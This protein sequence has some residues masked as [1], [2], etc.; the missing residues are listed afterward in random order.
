MT[1]AG[2]LLIL[3]FTALVALIARPMGLYLTAVFDGRRTWLSPV[4]A[5]VE[6]GLY[7]LAGLGSDSE[8]TWKGYAAALVMFSLVST[9][10]LLSLIHI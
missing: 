4:L 9:L 2:W 7:R 1:L 3:G 6:R 5:P 10:A 8:Q